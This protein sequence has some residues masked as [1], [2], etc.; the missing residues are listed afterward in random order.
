MK[1]AFCGAAE[2]TLLLESKLRS[3]L[4]RRE[5]SGEADKSALQNSRL[6]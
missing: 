4:G 1:T 3:P 2:E 5:K 6:S